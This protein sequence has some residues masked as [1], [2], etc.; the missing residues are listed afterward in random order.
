MADDREDSHSIQH[1]KALNGMRAGGSLFPG[2]LQ[3]TFS[4]IVSGSLCLSDDL[5]GEDVHRHAAWQR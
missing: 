5:R 2:H 1:S 3:E 4:F